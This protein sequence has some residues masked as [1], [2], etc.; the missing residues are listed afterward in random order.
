LSP[1]VGTR[2]PEPAQD[3]NV[4]TPEPFDYESIPV[5]YYDE[6]FRR[7]RGTQS[8]WHH[9]KFRRVSEEL[10]GHPRVLDVGCGPGTMIGSLAA[11]RD[12]VGTDLSTRQIEYA[13]TTYGSDS[14]RFYASTP[15]GLPDDEGPFDAVTLVELIEHLDPVVVEATIDEALDRLRPGGKLVLTTPNFRS[16]WPLIEAVINRVSDVTY[17]FQHINKFHA[18]RLADLLRSHG[19]ESV[20]VEPYLFMAPFVA[21][22]SWELSDRVARLERGPVERRMGML[23]LG[24]GIKPG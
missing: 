17:D 3:S 16:V 5:G 15:A 21:S 9:L 1:L 7:G 18:A 22:L 20:R 2:A 19:L 14:A 13:K 10:Q 4:V 23:L 8:K 12:W 6:V 11:G 24:T